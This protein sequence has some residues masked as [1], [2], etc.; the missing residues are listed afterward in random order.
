MEAGAE[1]YPAA[2][3]LVPEMHEAPEAPVQEGKTLQQSLWQ[4]SSYKP[5]LQ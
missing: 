2:S 3:H 5:L 1:G 4:E